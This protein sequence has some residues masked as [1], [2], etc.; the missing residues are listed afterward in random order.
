[1]K[2]S[3]KWLSGV[4]LVYHATVIV[5]QMRGRVPER[6]KRIVSGLPVVLT[7]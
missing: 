3:A 6:L 4:K 2:I 1:M 5:V 7:R